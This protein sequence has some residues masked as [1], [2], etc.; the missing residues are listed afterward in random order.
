MKVDIKEEKFDPGYDWSKCGYLLDQMK[1]QTF[2]PLPELE[3]S[4]R[5]YIKMP[6]FYA[7]GCITRKDCPRDERILN[8]TQIWILV[9]CL[10]LM[11][12][13]TSWFI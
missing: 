4:I 6:P 3:T 10:C 11:T 13:Q 5:K 9:S 12:F 8:E 1:C 2:D 7:T